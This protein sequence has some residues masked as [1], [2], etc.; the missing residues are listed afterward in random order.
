MF[1]VNHSTCKWV[2][3]NV[4]VGEGEC[5]VIL[6]HH[7]DPTSLFFLFFSVS[8]KL[9]GEL[10]IMVLKWYPCLVCPHIVCVCPV[11]LVGELDLT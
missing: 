2:F 7:L 3:F 10:P 1:Y 4:F 5:H 8:M 11:A 9:G 6:L